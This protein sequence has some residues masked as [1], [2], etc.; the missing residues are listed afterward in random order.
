MIANPILYSFA[1]A[2]HPN[3]LTW[4]CEFG[5]VGVVKKL[6]AAGVNPNIPAAGVYL[7]RSHRMEGYTSWRIKHWPH[8]ERKTAA[9]SVLDNIYRYDAPELSYPS[10]PRKV[11]EILE[12]QP[13]MHEPNMHENIVL[14]PKDHYGYYWFPLHGAAMAGS[15]EIVKL[16]VDAGAHLDAP[17]RGLSDCRGAK[18]LSPSQQTLW[19]P[20]HTALSFRNE[21]TANLLLNLGASP[22]VEYTPPT[23]RQSTALHWAA[24]GGCLSTIRLLLGSESKNRGISV[25]VQDWEGFTPLMWALGTTKSTETMKCLLDYGANME[26]RCIPNRYEGEATAIL[27]ACDNGW[28]RDV[29]FLMKAGA[30]VDY[31]DLSALERCLATLGGL[32]ERR[33]ETYRLVQLESNEEYK[34]RAIEYPHCQYIY[35]RPLFADVSM[36]GNFSGMLRVTQEL[37]RRGAN[38]HG[39]RNAGHSPLVR[40]CAARLVP[41]VETLIAAGSPVDQEDARGMTPLL[42][43]VV[44]LD[45]RFLQEPQLEATLKLYSRDYETIE[46]LLR[47]RADPN[48]AI[49]SGQ[50]A[51]V[52]ACKLM[53]GKRRQLKI[54]QLLVQYGADI[55]LRSPC[56]QSAFSRFGDPQHICSPIRVAFLQDELDVC[57]YFL[58][59]GVKPPPK[60]RELCHMLIYLVEEAKEFHGK[61]RGH[62]LSVDP[63]KCPARF[64]VALR[65]LLEIDREGWLAR[66]PKCLWWST[67]ICHFP[68][69]QRLLDSGAQD[70]SW[71]SKISGTCLHNLATTRYANTLACAQRLIDLGA[72]VDAVDKYRQSALAV[73]LTCD[74]Q[75]RYPKD[76]G[77]KGFINLLEILLKNGATQRKEDVRHFQ[78]LVHQRKGHRGDSSYL[79]LQE[80]LSVHFAVENG[81]IVARDPE[82]ILQQSTADEMDVS[83]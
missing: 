16:L 80:A 45:G 60:D 79:H 67:R 7:G 69:T 76:I 48:K 12:F 34:R 26:V 68:L 72:D 70:A 41:I 35:R 18:W 58:K 61:G 6:L 55:D 8:D 52:S 29:D 53:A 19:T 74:W 14:Y 1:V 37:I 32:P 62:D 15:L 36:K 71:I 77:V 75:A 54:V 38:I 59:Q 50:T 9:L 22:N 4:A 44:G 83:W 82:A 27:H 43:A 56:P 65:L 51:L 10:Y 64:C 25:D 40:A 42:A 28:Y 33:Q 20:L 81:K 30:K 13:N 73:L 46:C 63:M 24:V 39:S 66:D 31:S 49:A 21:A 47:H 78:N 2:N 57:R 11:G 5:E 17:S 3:L 23:V